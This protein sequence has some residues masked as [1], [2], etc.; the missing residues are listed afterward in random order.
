ML[1]INYVVDDVNIDDLPDAENINYTNNATV[2]TPT[3]GTTQLQANE[4]KTKYK[5]LK[6]TINE[7][8]NQ[9]LKKLTKKKQ[10]KQKQI[11]QKDDDAAFVKLVPLHPRKILKS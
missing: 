7:K 10:K 1:I 3:K 11:S 6:R 2:K 4:I 5:N 9:L 8:I